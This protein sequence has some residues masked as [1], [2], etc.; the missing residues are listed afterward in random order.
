MIKRRLQW[1]LMSM[2]VLCATSAH[3]EGWLDKLSFSAWGGHSFSS[4]NGIPYVYD[5]DANA[6]LSQ[7]L[8]SGTSWGLG[9]GFDVTPDWVANLDY[10]HYHVSGHSH[11]D[12]NPA[13]TDD[14]N[15]TPLQGLIDDCY[16][17][18]NSSSNTTEQEIAL[19]AGRRFAAGN[20]AFV[21]YAGLEYARLNQGINNS[22]PY[23]GGVSGYAT[24]SDKYSGF[25]PKIGVKGNVPLGSTPFF[26]AG[27]FS[28]A[29]LLTG[30]RKQSIDSSEVH[31]PGG[32]ISGSATE[33]DSNGRRP[34][35]FDFSVALGYHI[36][37]AVDV[38]LGWR[39]HEV[40]GVLDTQPTNESVSFGDAPNSGSSID[41]LI[42]HTVFAKF[43]YH[44]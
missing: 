36:T 43:E 5:S 37:S 9:T 2:T 38:T 12:T 28:L 32:G 18:A 15:A 26:V 8:G 10:A 21:G 23:E 24:R 22:Y 42:F 16:D 19:T 6:T 4:G 31:T 17:S 29:K 41:N 30:N 20:A 39:F 3:A 1:I 11:F 25:G 33:S 14:C 27:D 40:H 13:V 7:K 35:I 44:L 34:L